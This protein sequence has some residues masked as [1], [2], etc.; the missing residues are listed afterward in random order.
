M[1]KCFNYF[2]TSLTSK[3]NSDVEDIFKDFAAKYNLENWGIKL[4]E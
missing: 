1:K 3:Q 2:L 4:K